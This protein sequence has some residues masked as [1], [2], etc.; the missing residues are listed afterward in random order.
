MPTHIVSL[1]G[2]GCNNTR[3]QMLSQLHTLTVYLFTPSFVCWRQSSERAT[4][5]RQSESLF[6]LQRIQFL[7]FSRRGISRPSICKTEATLHWKICDFFC[8]FF[9]NVHQNILRLSSE[10]IRHSERCSRKRNVIPAKFEA[11]IRRFPDLD[12]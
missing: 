7:Y 10:T 3:T 12:L 1:S 11:L 9:C 2:V 5:F 4:Q 8:K 6:V